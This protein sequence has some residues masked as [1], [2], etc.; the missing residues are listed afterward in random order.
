[1]TS[2][3]AAPVSTRLRHLALALAPIAF[4]LWLYREGLDIWFLQDDFAWLGLLRQVHSRSDLVRIL[5]EPAA[6]GTIRP[7]SER[8][9][10]LLFEYLFGM[11]SLPF[12]IA[13]FATAAADILL[14]GWVVHR[15]SASRVAAAVAGAAWVANAAVLAASR[16]SL[17]MV[18]DQPFD[19]VALG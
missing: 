9:F 11:D 14:I 3:P 6:Q 16:S 1:M 10:F 5:F 7:W 19:I 18:T 4:L 17:M 12:R 2:S 8:G 15:I 13:A